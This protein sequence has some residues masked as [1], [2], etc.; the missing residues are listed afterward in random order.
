VAEL[1]VVGHSIPRV[2]ALDKVTGSTRY[3]VDLKVPG[4]LYGKILRS[5]HP[6]ARIIGIDSSGAERHPGVKA[7][8]TGNDAPTVRF[9]FL[10][11]ERA[12]FPPDVVRFAGEGVAGVAAESKEAAEEALS[13]I[14]VDYEELPAVFDPEEAIKPNPATVV[15]PDYLKYGRLPFRIQFLNKPELPNV[16]AYRPMVRGDVEKGF[17]ESDLVMENRFSTGRIHHSAM[18]PLGAT[19]RFEPD[20]SLTVWTALTMPFFTRSSLCSLFGLPSSKVKLI[21][22]PSGGSFGSRAEATQAAQAALLALKAGRPVKLVLSREEFVLDGGTREPMVVYVKDGVR[23]DGTLVARHVRMIVH[24]GAYCGIMAITCHSCTFAAAATYRVPNL[25]VDSYAVATNEPPAVALRG[26]GAGQ[27]EMAIESQMD[28]LAEKLEM[29]SADIRRKN[30][31][32][33][34]EEDGCGMLVHSIGVVDCLDKI[35]EWIDRNKDVSREEGPWRRASGIAIINRQIPAGTTSVVHVKVHE[36]GTTEVRHSAHDQGQGCDTVLAQI[37]AEE[38][39]TSVD[40]VKVRCADAPLTCFDHGTVGSRTTMHNGNALLLACQDA[41]RQLFEL[42]S[43]KLSVPPDGL[44]VKDGVVYVKGVPERVVRV[45][46]LFTPLGY[47]V[48]GGELVGRGVYTGPIGSE[49]LQTG[50]SKRPSMGYSHGAS[51]AEVAVN[52]ETGEVRVLHIADCYDMGQPINPEMCEGQIEGGRGIA[53]GSTLSEEVVVARGKTIST[54]FM[55]YKIPTA[56]D[57]PANDRS[58]AMM[59]TSHHHDDGPF[60][61]KGFCEGTML[62]QPPAVANAIYNAVGVRMKDIPITREKV[63]EALKN[64]K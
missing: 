38:F 33:E 43:S 6:H 54:D 16:Y 28:M 18:E 52:T 37:A 34:G 7:V 14:K 22:P 35:T 8:V 23:K 29:D 10:A 21:V 49:D 4:M 20:G 39:K 48:R 13:L 44:D 63:L 12:I 26:F 57:L 15:H 30:I 1:S 53:L 46:E 51:A 3:A 9:G 58:V 60:G 19:A 47:L 62:P 56:A 5:P 36:D 25:K 61:A 64:K 41:K 50:Q 59:V 55:D 42:A 45:S 11:R 32:R 40:R 2:D 17:E 31:L 24:A 27:V